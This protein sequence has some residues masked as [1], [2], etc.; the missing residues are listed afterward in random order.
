[1]TDDAECRARVQECRMGRN[2]QSRFWCGFCRKLI[3]LKK[4]GCEAWAETFDHIGDHF[5]KEERRIHNWM[6]VD[7]DGPMQRLRK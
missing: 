3:D 4:K 1:M 6:P 7:Y 5:E 2:C